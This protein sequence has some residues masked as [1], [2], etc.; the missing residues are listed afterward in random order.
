[1]KN[2]PV[3]P[4]AHRYRLRMLGMLLVVSWA[5]LTVVNRMAVETD[6]RLVFLTEQPDRFPLEMIPAALIPAEKHASGL[7]PE[8]KSHCP[9]PKPAQYVPPRARA[10]VSHRVR[11]TNEVI[12]PGLSSSS[13]AL[14][15][16]QYSVLTL[17]G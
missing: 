11:S 16:H 17:H 8:Q 14:P 5:V 13:E 12:E 1:M 10:R 7:S 6:E 9:I 15:G 2:I 4:L 3:P